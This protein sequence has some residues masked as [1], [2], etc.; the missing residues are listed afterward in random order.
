MEG[1]NASRP[2][3]FELRTTSAGRSYDH[4]H[5]RDHSTGPKHRRSSELK[6]REGIFRA[7]S[8]RLFGDSISQEDA[9]SLSG[10]AAA[11]AGVPTRIALELLKHMPGEFV[12]LSR[13]IGRTERSQGRRADAKRRDRPAASGLSGSSGTDY[14]GENGD[15]DAASRSETTKIRDGKK[16]AHV[17][18]NND[19]GRMAT[20][21]LTGADHLSAVMVHTLKGFEVVQ[22]TGEDGK[23]CRFIPAFLSRSSLEDFWYAMSTLVRTNAL[24]QRSAQRRASNQLLIAKLAALAAS[25]GIGNGGESNA[26]GG[27][28]GFGVGNGEDS[29]MEGFEDPAE[30][31]EVIREIQSGLDMAGNESGNDDRSTRG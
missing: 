19:G 20:G 17:P 2:L 27:A 7:R 23:V 14:E 4:R 11:L 6:G 30:V 3:T 28:S 29:D 22:Q 12:L 18:S 15:D 24:R 1:I 8:K 10:K 21:V 25:S 13:Y 16:G 9:V 31:Q 26:G 5:H